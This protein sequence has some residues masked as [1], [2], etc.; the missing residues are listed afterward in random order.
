MES[1]GPTRPTPTP[2]S[3]TLFEK[4]LE[5][6]HSN[7]TTPALSRAPSLP[8]K[9]EDV[10]EANQQAPSSPKSHAQQDEPEPEP[11]RTMHG[12]KWILVCI[13]IYISA[14]LYGLDTT[15][16]ADVQGAVVEQ[17][18]HVDQISWIGSG[19]PL[20]SVSVILLVGNMYGHFNM[21]W[22]YVGSILLFEVGSTLCGAAP[23]MNALIVGRVLAGA[24]GSGIYLGGLNYFSYLTTPKE[25]GLYITL[26]GFHWGVGA[27]LGPIIGGAF[28]VS[29][30]TWR[31]AFYINLVIGAAVSPIYIFFL[32]P[33]HPSSGESVRERIGTFDFVGLVLIAAVWVTFTLGFSMAGGPW[34]WDD[35]RTI[36]VLV[37]FGV[38][39]VMAALQQYFTLFTSQGGRAFP[40]H[41]L[42]SRTQI[43]LFVAT[44]AS[45]TSLFVVVYYIPIYFQFVHSDS[46][47]EAAVRLLP[48]IVVTVVTN[49]LVGHLL[50]RLRI[51]MVLYVVSGVL[52]TVGGTLLM[53]QLDPSTSEATIY[54]LTVLIA[55]GT[56]MTVQLGYAVGTLTVKPHDMGHAISFQ[57]VSQIGSTVLC[58]VIAG[59]IFQSIAV[60]NLTRVLAGLGFSPSDIESAVAGTQSALFGQ[61][62]PQLRSAAIAAIVQAMQKS[63][64]LVIVAGAV[65]LVASV[66]M[67]RER[68]FGDIVT[69]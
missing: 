24:G 56:G 51:Y 31:W 5:P 64:V 11:G 1:T 10:E 23:N 16:A 62:S 18:G 48:F 27:V 19:F 15:I 2:R 17:F 33:I 41:L 61:L 49:V 65:M 50:S 42:K 63:F 52:I 43:L 40:G 53:T 6:G 12:V 26:I 30:A 22:I 39:L 44:A 32:P 7:G 36:A 9:S 37:V 20:G 58:L 60:S 4:P 57:N 55:F 46:A 8:R 38:L 68:L 59:Q 14:F 54:G 67:K 47:I 34:G 3:S 35:G 25:R 29:S 21:K 28:S 66:G 13:S 69:V 45:T